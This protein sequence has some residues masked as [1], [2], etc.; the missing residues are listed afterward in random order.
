MSLEINLVDQVW[1]WSLMIIIPI[2]CVCVYVC[3]D[4]S[5]RYDM[6]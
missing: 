4:R 1:V 6:M 2:K 3:V 5:E